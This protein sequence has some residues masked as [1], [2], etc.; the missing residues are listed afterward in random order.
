M[1]EIVPPGNDFIFSYVFSGC[2][3]FS[4]TLSTLKKLVEVFYG[5]DFGLSVLLGELGAMLVLGL[6]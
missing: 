3:S 4:S 5:M 1:N 6:L 2:S